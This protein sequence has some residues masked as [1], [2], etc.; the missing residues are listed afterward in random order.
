MR[1]FMTCSGAP[2]RAARQSLIPMQERK[3]NTVIDF[4]IVV[5]AEG[6]AHRRVHR[7]TTATATESLKMAAKLQLTGSQRHAPSVCSVLF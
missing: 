4:F 2:V 5:M 7:T 3:G 6:I 1:S